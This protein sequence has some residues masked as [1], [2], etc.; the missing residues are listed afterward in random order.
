MS[1]QPQVTLTIDG[2]SITVPAGTLVVDAA[3]MA[4]VDI[5]VFCY[6]PKMEPVGMCRMCLVEIG[7]PLRDRAT[8]EFVREED[9]SIRV[10]FGPRLETACTVRVS[11]GMVVRTTTEKVLESRRSILEFL[12]TSHPL[13]CPICDKGGECALQ[14][15]TMAWG[16]G[17][18]RFFYEDKLHLAKRVPL[19]DLIILDRER[20]IMCARCIRFQ[21]DV[22]DDPVL[23]FYHRG[24]YTDI[25][26]VSEPGFDSYWSGN[27]TDICPVGALTTVD[28]RFGAR[29]WEMRPAASICSHCPVG[30]NL[31]FDVRR[32]AA[33]EG[34]FVVK[35]AMPRQ[36]E[37]VNE[38]WICDKGRFAGYHFAEQPDRLTRPLIRKNGELV[39]ATWEEALDLVALRFRTAQKLLTLVGGRLPNEDLYNLGALTEA[40]GGTKALYTFMAGGDL[41]ARLGLGAGHNLADLGQGD[42]I[43]VVASDLEEEAPLWWLRTKQAAERGAT[44]VV[45]NP[46]PTKLERYARHVLRYA[47]GE[48]AATMAGLLEGES[49]AARALA[50]AE[51]LVIFF[52]QEGADVLTSR[53]LAAA[54]ARLLTET[55]HAGKP[56]SGLVGVWPR[57]NDQGAWEQGFA[58]LDDWAEA[59]RQ[60]DALYIAAADPAGDDPALAQALER[61]G[62]VVVQELFLTETAKRADV[63][64][65]VQ[66]VTERSG[67]F[68]SGERQVQRFYQAVPPVEGTRPDYRIAAE[69]AARL[70]VH[71]EGSSAAR[72]FEAGLAVSVPA[73]A[74]LTYVQ[75]AEVVEQW[76]LLDRHDLYYGGTVYEN[77][78][79]VGVA[80]PNAAQRGEA[81]SVPEVAAPQRPAVNGLLAVPIT[82]LYDRG[83]LLTPSTLK[84]RLPAR[85]FV[86]LGEAEARRLGLRHRSEATLVLHGT[87]YTV[88][89]QVQAEVPEGVVLVPR[90]LGIPI[91]GPTDVSLRAVEPALA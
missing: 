68:T 20:C 77:K 67:T 34:R 23:Q 6:H 55:G 49:E 72:A 57:A 63:V 91:S 22:V 90:S 38:I 4:G 70:D 51:N 82:R 21:R 58:P 86:V 35:R 41:V 65:P 1:D 12:L 47:Y 13:D 62:F 5:P 16:P 15:L 52:G 40:L 36:N 27:T 79:G 75:L 80:L 71:L 32:E 43:L 46:R 39:P 81:V 24:R 50:Q 61:A 48:E 11:E 25:I 60:A 73:F 3:R 45:A 17:E 26:T 33:S 87:P 85:P 83:A 64:L 59:F 37:W 19:G 14:N 56:N 42:A 2:K 8:G 29:P 30:C 74:R 89:V 69:I 7:R 53:A 54:C 78:Q 31:T 66:A 28:F 84:V 76:P 10:Q 44:L 88:Q 18:S 9:G